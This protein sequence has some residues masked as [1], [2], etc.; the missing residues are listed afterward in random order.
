MLV[1]TFPMSTK[2][3]RSCYDQTGGLVYFARLAEKIRL[4]A[5]GALGKDYLDNL[6][7]GFDERC[8]N[9]LGVKYDDLKKQVLAGASDETALQWCLEHGRHPGADEITEF[10]EF[11]IKR[12]WR[13]SATPRL[14]LRLKEAKLEHRLGE[15]L[16]FF[17]FI[18]V[19]EG[20]T[21]PKFP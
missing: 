17:D 21:P 6:G 20:R 10:N 13:D 14:R 3:P 16:T 7:K 11:L 8:C 2:F 4:H 19:D 1:P 5:A 9:F 18:E 12:G 15:I